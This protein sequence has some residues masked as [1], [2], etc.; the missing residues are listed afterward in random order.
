M[1]L[2]PY[3]ADPAPVR[4]V[5]DNPPGAISASDLSDLANGLAGPQDSSMTPGVPQ[6]PS[7]PQDID[8]RRFD[9]QPGRN[10]TPRPRAFEQYNYA[11]FRQLCRTYDVARIA[12]EARKDEVRSWEWDIRVRPIAGLTRE[13]QRARAATFADKVARVKGFLMS[14]NQE[15]DWGTWI[16][17]Y[18]HE[19]LVVDAP[20][21][22]RRPNKAGKP[23][24]LEIIDGTTL[25][26]LIDYYGRTPAP[27]EPAFAQVIHG[28][29]WIYFT[30]NEIDFHP[31]HQSIESPYGSPPIEWVI[32][33]VNRALR[34]QSLDLSLFN[35][36]TLPLQYY[37]VPETWG[38]DQLAA[39]QKIFDSLLS[40]DDL[41][42]SR[43]RFVPGGTGTGPESMYPTPET[44]AKKWLMNVTAA[45][46][47]STA[48]DLGFDP[49]GSGLG[50]A[51]YG[52]AQRGSAERRGSKPTSSYLSGLVNRFIATWLGAPELE[53]VWRGI[54]QTEDLLKQAQIR[55]IEWKT[56]AYSGDEW[57]EDV[58]RDLIG[59]DPTILDPKIG[60]I[61]VEDLI[62][63]RANTAAAE[64]ALAQTLVDP[65]GGALLPDPTLSAAP[66]VP[67]PNTLAAPSAAP[68]ETT[69]GVSVGTPLTKVA[70]AE[71]AQWRRMAL[72]RV[73]VGRDPSAFETSAIPSDV[74]QV[75]A[76]QLRATST[77]AA[78][79]EVFER[80]VR[81]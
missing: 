73:A 32:V 38:G 17:T 74:Y 56:G 25:A 45:A 19:V 51:G 28:L 66:V 58:G 29:P 15:D 79:R 2:R 70:R 53:F 62:A 78:V 44:D 21:I 31:Y 3:Q 9:Y 7:R 1:T 75:T 52:E 42:R 16:T 69:P 72:N 37:K 20:A 65:S 5:V 54:G 71:L 11:T 50:G 34:R 55:E 13:D 14:P 43:V 6:A 59:L 41:A 33:A 57:R 26:L 61:F 76:E 12:I 23:Y 49:T 22:Y 67:V 24:A 77:P 60:A 47:G 4:R 81:P 40:G 18:M 68:G 35:Q 46:F 64:A 80:I 8:P 36:G 27:P 30:T 63:N 39:L 10:I 48:Q